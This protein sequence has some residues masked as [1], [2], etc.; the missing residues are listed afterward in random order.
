MTVLGLLVVG[1]IRGWIVPGREYTRVVKELNQTTERLSMALSIA[2]W[3]R[4]SMQ[5]KER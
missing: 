4:Q 3:V 5:L 2:D 1:F